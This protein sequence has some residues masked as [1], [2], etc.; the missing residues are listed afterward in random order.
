[1]LNQLRKG[2]NNVSKKEEECGMPRRRFGQ[3]LSDNL[4]HHD[5]SMKFSI[6]V[7]LYL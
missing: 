1:V 5:T 6:T 3:E 4:V 7:K 2:K